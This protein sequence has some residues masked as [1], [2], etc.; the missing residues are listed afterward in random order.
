M[1][2]KQTNNTTVTYASKI[3]FLGYGAK[4]TKIIS[5]LRS[6]N[7]HVT[8]T[9]DLITT[10]NG[11]DLIISFGYKHILSEELILSTKSPFINL[12]ISYLP[13]NRGAHPNFW[14]FYD[15]TPSGVT[16]HMIEKDLDKGNIIFQKRVNFSKEE[17]TFSST[18]SRLIFELEELFILNI[19]KILSADYLSSPQLPG[20]SYH[21]RSDLPKDFSGWDSN[22]DLEIARL[23]NLS[24]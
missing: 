7:C 10:V 18:Y 15:Q 11:Y 4:E 1:S 24:K 21:R 23:H 17:I 13:W 20:G 12:H 8:Q 3:L 16:I 22:I 6:R 19:D 9:K 5:A 2:L 14:A